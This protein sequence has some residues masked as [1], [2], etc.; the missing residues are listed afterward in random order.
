M[1]FNVLVSLVQ[2]ALEQRPVSVLTLLFIGL[3]LGVHW[4]H[5]RL[6]FFAKS[7]WKYRF[8]DT[9]LAGWI[10]YGTTDLGINAVLQLDGCSPTVLKKRWEGQ[11]YLREKLQTHPTKSPLLQQLVDCRFLL[12][13]LCMPLLRELEFSEYQGN[14]FQEL[15]CRS[16]DTKETQDEGKT[17]RSEEEEAEELDQCS[18]GMHQ[19]VLAADTK[20]SMAYVGGDAVHTLSIPHFYQPVQAEIE[21]RLRLANN[22]NNQSSPSPSSWLRFAPIA[23]N[24]ELEQHASYLLELT[25]MDQVRYS[26]SGS[27]AMEAAIKDVRATARNFASHKKY[28]VRFQSAYHGHVSG[29]DF[30]NARDCIY[31]KECDDDALAFIEQYHYRI[32]GVIVN[33]MQHFTGINQ[34]S[35]PGEKL[36]VSRRIRTS[37]SRADYARWLHALQDKCHYCTTYLTPV[38]LILDDIYFAFRTPELFSTQYFVHPETKAPLQPDVLVLGKGLAAGYPLSVVL[39]RRGVLNTY[40]KKYLLQVNK[41]VGTLSAWYGGVVASNVFLRA[42]QWEKN[43]TSGDRYLSSDFELVCSAKQQLRHMMIKFDDFATKL[44]AAYEKHDLPL[45]V[46]NFS[47]VFSINYKASSLYNSRYPQ[48][49]IAHGVALGNYTT[50]KFNLNADATVQDLQLLVDKF[51]AAALAM[52]QHGY[53]EECP[54]WNRYRLYA[55]LAGRFGMNLLQLYYDQMMKDKEVDIDVSHNHPVNKF[56]HFW[57][58]VV[59]ILHSYPY[60]FW[61]GDALTGCI[62]FFV[63]HVVR[64]SGHFFYERQD[65]NVEKLKFGHKVQ[66]ICSIFV[67][68][69]CAVLEEHN[70]FL[71]PSI[72]VF[73]S[74]LKWIVSGWKQKGS[75]RLFGRSSPCRCCCRLDLGLCW[76]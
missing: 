29:V 34:P 76:R 72:L 4:I 35:P 37:V 14:F 21:K 61:Y 56:G 39:G 75:C 31:L 25:H 71:N 7:G 42:L 48:Y 30:L 69:Y 5:E 36:N 2:G 49:L 47:N 22:N 33:P 54:T 15:Y 38:P 50:G 23:L 46:R 60:C 55:R 8:M 51:V 43:N 67:C 52:H 13:K 53:F 6:V 3:S 59:M 28:V 16:Q 65:R 62:S 12:A 57:S 44:N 74:F 20:Q 18:S 24:P 17:K 9:Y 40:D 11:K 73:L 41:T 27:E 19:V 70:T 68:V 63:A 66:Y 58:S 64:Q 32:A 10:H 26:L 45:S 1:S